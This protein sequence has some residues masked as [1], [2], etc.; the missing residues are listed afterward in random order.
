MQKSYSIIEIF[1][2]VK[3]LNDLQRAISKLAEIR[4]TVPEE[5]QVRLAINGSYFKLVFEVSPKD[6]DDRKY[7]QSKGFS[8]W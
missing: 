2:G 8:R 7:Y 1:D 6:K 5:S 3:N 4:N